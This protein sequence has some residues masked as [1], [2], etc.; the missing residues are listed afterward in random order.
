MKKGKFS[1]G[2]RK[3]IKNFSPDRIF[4]LPKLITFLLLSAIFLLPLIIFPSAF[5]YVMIK[6]SQVQFFLLLSFLFLI[7]FLLKT[8]K[9]SLYR[10]SF[11]L[12]F[13]LYFLWNTV[14]L[15]Y[16]P[17]PYASI[18]Q[19]ETV[20]TLMALTFFTANFLEKEKSTIYVL[21][22]LFLPYSFLVVKELIFYIQ[23]KTPVIPSTFGNPNFFSAYLLLL[24]PLPLVLSL[25]FLKKRRILPLLG[26]SS[27]FIL[28]L[29]LIIVI[30]SRAAY[31]GI[32]ASFVY[33][34]FYFRKEILGGK[35]KIYLLLFVF[36]LLISGALFT[37][38]HLTSLKEAWEKELSQGTVGIRVKI[39]EGTWRMIKAKP[40]TGWGIGTYHLIYPRFR[41]PSYFLNPHSVNATVHAHN[42]F[43]EIWSETGIVGL[44]LFLW[45][46]FL[47][48]REGTQIKGGEKENFLVPGILSGITGLLVN[49]LFGVNLRFPA[50]PVLLFFLMGFIYSLRAE[51]KKFIRSKVFPPMVN[52]IVISSLILLSAWVYHLEVIKPLLSSVHLKKGIEYRYNLEWEKAIKEYNLSLYWNPYNLRTLYRLGFAYASTGRLE[53]ALQTYLRLKEIAP[54]YAEIDFNLGTLYLQKGEW[55]KA[56]KFLEK[57]REAN[58]YKPE[59][60]LNIAK[61]WEKKKNWKEAEKSLEKALEVDNTFLP[62][63][64]ELAELF[65]RRKNYEKAIY[66]LELA[67]EKYPHNVKIKK[68]LSY[69]KERVKKKKN[70]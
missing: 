65:L 7:S 29:I 52:S 57:A 50:S 60:H 45:I 19:W 32:L 21:W 51:K 15:L 8:G 38:T 68:I 5:N 62:A 49:N 40:L 61:V 37:V 25:Y 34:I 26:L 13:L 58:P 59:T 31:I 4:P 6:L 23:E 54:Y 46:I 2:K 12:P 36:L 35:R 63:Y 9:V 67:R 47:L 27:L 11:Y 70:D 17:Y 33:L 66:Y 24:L 1:D 53:K 41:I 28:A 69:L 3:K 39:W 10:F 22:V 64:L 20:I 43:L 18:T 56:L 30:R 44:T 48:Y 14:S 42:E 55:D 16:S